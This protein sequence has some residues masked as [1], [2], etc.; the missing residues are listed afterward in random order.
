LNSDVVMCMEQTL[1]MHSYTCRTYFNKHR[2]SRKTDFIN[3]STRK[4]SSD[5]G[6]L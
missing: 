3:S 5:V 4:I 2:L 6:Q 1:Q